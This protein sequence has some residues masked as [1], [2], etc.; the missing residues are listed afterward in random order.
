[1][2][3]NIA[4]QIENNGKIFEK[5]YNSLSSAISNLN[6]QIEKIVS[7]EFNRLIDSAEADR[8]MKKNIN[9]MTLDQFFKVAQPNTYDNIPD[10]DKERFAKQSMK[11]RKI[12]KTS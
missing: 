1:M 5:D 11:K 4:E 2:N 8:I 6:S 3:N 7:D 10:A 12:R 9:K